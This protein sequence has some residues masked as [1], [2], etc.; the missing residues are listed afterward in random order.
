MREDDRKKL[1]YLERR[2]NILENEIEEMKANLDNLQRT[3]DDM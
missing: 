2:V 1:K 3:I